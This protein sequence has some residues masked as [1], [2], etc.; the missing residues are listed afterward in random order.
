MPSQEVS[1]EF[2]FPTTRW[3][4]VCRAGTGPGSEARRAMEQ[5]LRAYLPALRAHLLFD[6]RMDR[7]RAD[8]VLQAFVTDKLIEQNIVA[9]ANPSRGRFRNFLLVTLQR[10]VIDRAR[11][12]QS[13]RRAP[14]RGKLQSLDDQTDEAIVYEKHPS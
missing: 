13:L 9:A 4:V 14:E 8:D 5:L 2:E 6:R 7:D 3:S 1:D 10:F 11:Q 12:E